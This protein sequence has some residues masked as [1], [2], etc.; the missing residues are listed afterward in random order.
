MLFQFGLVKLRGGQS[1]LNVGLNWLD[2]IAKTFL[3]L[4]KS[5]K[6]RKCFVLI[7][8]N[9]YDVYH[10]IYSPSLFIS[11]I[12]SKIKAVQSDKNSQLGR[13]WLHQLAYKLCLS[14]M[15]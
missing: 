6:N 7:S 14:Q 3:P 11:F 12:K 10:H 8:R 1:D 4:K 15:K 13:F 2:Y 5:S 9:V